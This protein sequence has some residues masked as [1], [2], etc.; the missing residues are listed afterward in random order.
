[1]K[2]I[3]T[4]MFALIASASAFAV[5]TYTVSP[6]EGS[7]QNREDLKTVT[8]T[9]SE[10]V[11]VPTAQCLGG[12]RFNSTYTEVEL[13]MATASK[14]VVV[15]VPAE[16]WGEP[17]SGEYALSVNLPAIY[18]KAGDRIMVTL[19]DEDTQEEYEDAYTVSVSYTSPYLTNAQYIGL[20]PDPDT[21]TVWDVYSEGWGFVNFLFD[22]EVSL[23]DTAEA[24]I[25]FYL[26]GNKKVS[27]DISYDDL[28]ADWDFWT[29]AYA[30]TVPM[31]PDA[32]ITQEN[33]VKIEVE[34]YDVMVGGKAHDYDATYE[35]VSVPQRIAKSNT[36]SSK[37]TLSEETSNIVYDIHGRVVLNTANQ[38]VKELP[39]GIYVMGGKKFVVR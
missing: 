8:F 37:L 26:T 35:L 24:M 14:T 1:M 38:S 18:D 7:I 11:T 9:F 31:M 25:T 2:K 13:N 28:W 6:A 23:A 22:D 16:A 34:L 21:T 27:M 4:A 15:A 30:I 39:A 29:G 17:A 20:D 5:P 12:T 19:K 10:E 3:F 33:L 36:A 32:S